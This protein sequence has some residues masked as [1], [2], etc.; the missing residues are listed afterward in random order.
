MKNPK[1]QIRCEILNTLLYLLPVREQREKHP[2]RWAILL[3]DFLPG[4]NSGTLDVATR[5]AAVS[6]K[7][8]AVSFSPVTLCHGGSRPVNSG[9]EYM[10][11]HWTT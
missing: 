10:I 1:L 6:G 7:V 9:L 3:S 8:T 11:P 4:I 2:Q 5:E